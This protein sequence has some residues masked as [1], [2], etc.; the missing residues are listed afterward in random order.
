MEMERGSHNSS[1]N[2]NS[3]LPRMTSRKKERKTLI[4]FSG[5]LARKD[6][7]GKRC[8]SFLECVWE[9]YKGGQFKRANG[10]SRIE[11]IVE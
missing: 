11:L 5:D 2:N 7:C 1:S 4:Y 6:F 8:L 10:A 3:L 9:K